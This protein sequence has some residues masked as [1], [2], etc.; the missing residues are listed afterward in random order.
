[1]FGGVQDVDA[2][3]EMTSSAN[4]GATNVLIELEDGADMGKI[5]DE[6]ESNVDSISTFP[7]EAEDPRVAEIAF[8]SPVLEVAVH[9]N[10]DERSLKRLG[11]QLRDDIAN[12]PGVSKVVSSG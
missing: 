1:M 12:L 9:G 3:E 11:Q 8:S 6:I 10:V 5:L 7:S 2:I 4:E